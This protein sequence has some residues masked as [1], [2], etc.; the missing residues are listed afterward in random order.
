M[1]LS[2]LES[3]TRHTYGLFM[4]SCNKYLD[5]GS[6]PGSHMCQGKSAQNWGRRLLLEPLPQRWVPLKLS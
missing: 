2:R 6:C 5:V 3:R 4:A 1:H